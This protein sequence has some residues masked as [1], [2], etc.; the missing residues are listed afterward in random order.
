[1][2][3]G[4]QTAALAS[5]AVVFRPADPPR[6]SRVAFWRPAGGE[7]P[8]GLGEPGELELVVGDDSGVSSRQVA[9]VE[10]PIG[11]AVPVLGRARSDRQAHPTAAFWGAAALAGLQLV[12][13]GRLLPGVSPDGY[14]AWRVGPLDA[15]DV[16]RVLKLAE[17]MPPEARAVPLAG[18]ELR[19]PP[20]EDLVRSFLDAVA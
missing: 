15:A 18:S 5:C 16:D 2:V 9:V 13:R 20:A 8:I 6:E 19:L 4:L 11:Q 14:D 10:L 7:L 12:A 3:T 17:A 1:M